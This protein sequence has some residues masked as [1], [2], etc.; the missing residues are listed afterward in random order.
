ME[1]LKPTSVNSTAD[2]KAGDKTSLTKDDLTSASGSLEN[3]TKSKELDSSYVALSRPNVEKLLAEQLPLNEGQ[4]FTISSY[5]A[6]EPVDKKEPLYIQQQ[7]VNNVNGNID[8]I[9][10]GKDT[11]ELFNT[12]QH[13]LT[14]SQSVHKNIADIFSSLG[15]LDNDTES[16]LVA[17]Q[18]YIENNLT[19]KLPAASAENQFAQGSSLFDLPGA[20][21][22]G[23]TFEVETQEGDTI[24]VTYQ[25]STSYGYEEG[26]N[27]L[28]YQVDGELSEEEQEALNQLFIG[29]AEYVGQMSVGDRKEGGLDSIDIAESFDMSLLKGFS[30]DTKLFGQQSHYKYEVNKA[31]QEQTLSIEMNVSG[32]D[33][34]QSF[35]FS[36]TTSLLGSKDEDEVSR[37]ALEMRDLLDEFGFRKG[38]HE[39]LNE[40][41][42]DSFTSLFDVNTQKSQ[43]DI[44]KFVIPTIGKRVGA[45]QFTSKITSLMD[46]NFS[47]NLAENKDRPDEVSARIKMSQKTESTSI[48]KLYEFTQQKNFS[49]YSYISTP[50]NAE[51]VSRDIVITNRKEKLENKV[52]VDGIQ[53]TISL[54]SKHNLD[55]R[56]EDTRIY[57]DGRVKT[58]VTEEAIVELSELKLLEDILTNMYTSTRETKKE[59]IEKEELDGAARVT[60]KSKA[61]DVY[62]QYDALKLK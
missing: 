43:H 19:N 10:D 32:R 47:L 6:P 48:G 21:S 22:M 62:M 37:Y 26:F 20:G 24:T 36:L 9:S 51:D 34:A 18:S 3:V 5:V 15:Q 31:T 23:V 41:I 45:N 17:S 16:Y 13:A 33:A 50:S 12:V 44:D 56:I 14:H 35:D 53:N 2:Y 58:L 52:K 59:T 27:G 55:N 29:S 11:A 54:V 39:L 60:A 42:V 8:R 28:S 38:D 7:Y 30:I 57:S 46:Y 61:L 49:L 25:R 40:F 1:L 4:Q